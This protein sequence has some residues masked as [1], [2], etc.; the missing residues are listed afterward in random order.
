MEIVGY[1]FRILSSQQNP[2]SITWF[3]LQY[4]LIVVAPVM[5][6]AA[7]YAVASVLINTYGR[8]S[9]PMPPKV[10]L[11]VFITCDIVATVVQVAGA[12][13]VGVSDER[14]E[15]CNGSD[16]KASRSHTRTRRIQPH[17]TTSSL[18]VWLSRC[19]LSRCSLQSS[20][21]Y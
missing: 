7:I 10:V 8:E 21:G 6:S 4:F 19:S 2:Y 17:I 13:L 16:I 15:V 14:H 1:V 5:F 3:V 20:P 9:A 11:G 12:A 18:Q